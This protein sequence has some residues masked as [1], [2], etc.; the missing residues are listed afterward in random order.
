[1]HAAIIAINGALDKGN[2]DV[3]LE[4]MLNP[5]ACLSGVTKDN[6]EDYQ[7][8]LADAKKVKCDAA[9]NKVKLPSTFAL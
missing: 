4:A 6:V 1:M 2:A 7:K 5:N 9:Q 3:T 8:R